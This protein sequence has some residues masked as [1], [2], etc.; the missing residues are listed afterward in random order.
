M[1]ILNRILWL[2]IITFLL[3]LTTFAQDPTLIQTDPNLHLEGADTYYDG[4]IVL[5]FTEGNDTMRFN[6]KIH[7]RIIFVN[8]AILPV[9]IV[10]NYNSSFV[11]EGSTLTPKA[12]IEGY[13]LIES[14]GITQ[15]IS[16]VSWDGTIH[17]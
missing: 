7:L 16:I 17:K 9:E 1:P 13:V 4:T 8:N 5:L 11:F 3:L 6:T 12:L 2:F 14:F 15:Q 10:Y